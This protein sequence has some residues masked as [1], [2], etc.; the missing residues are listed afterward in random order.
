M[1]PLPVDVGRGVDA[2]RLDVNVTAVDC[3]DNSYR[4]Q[5]NNC[6]ALCSQLGYSVHEVLFYSAHLIHS[7]ITTRMAIVNEDHWK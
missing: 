3:P 5:T 1:L 6:I 7:I 4:V 2:W